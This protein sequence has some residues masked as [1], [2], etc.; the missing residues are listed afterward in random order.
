MLVGMSKP[1]TPKL[2]P[3]QSANPILRW[4]VNKIIV[5]QKMGVDKGVRWLTHN[6]QEV[7]MLEKFLPTVYN[8]RATMVV[9]GKSVLDV[10][11]PSKKVKLFMAGNVGKRAAGVTQW[12]QNGGVALDPMRRLPEGGDWQTYP[13]PDDSRA[14]VF[15]DALASEI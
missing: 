4:I 2:Y 3:N 14:Q 13:D 15:Y 7:G 12:W 6:V 8:N 5:P 1:Q 10:W 11:A 9:P